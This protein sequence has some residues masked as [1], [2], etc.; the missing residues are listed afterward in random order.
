MVP[1]CSINI[2][3]PTKQDELFEVNAH[4]FQGSHDDDSSSAYSSPERSVKAENDTRLVLTNGI[5]EAEVL[6]VVE[7]GFD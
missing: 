2:K 4:I 3:V 5:P 6:S 1:F 7:G